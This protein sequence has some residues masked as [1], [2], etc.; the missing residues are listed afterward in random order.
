MARPLRLQCPAAAYHHTAQGH[1]RQRTIGADWIFPCPS[2]PDVSWIL[3]GVN[4]KLRLRYYA[5]FLQKEQDPQ[6][7]FG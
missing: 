3:P 6:I 5:D 4:D 7:R 1:T 2:D